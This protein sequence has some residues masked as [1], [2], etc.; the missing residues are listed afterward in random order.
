MMPAWRN[1]WQDLQPRE[2]GLISVGVSLL[3]CGLLYAYLWLP[4]SHQR[5]R[6]HELM[7]RFQMQ[8]AQLNAARDE[9]LKLKAQVGTLSR[10]QLPLRQVLE[11]SSTASGIRAQIERIDMMGDASAT[12]ALGSVSF[13]SWLLWLKE[14]QTKHS[15]R[16][17][18]C[19][20]TATGQTGLVK[21][22]ASVMRE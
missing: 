13:D 14:L 10:V 16:L 4:L 20:I 19:E 11:D 17:S 8:A 3:F 2:R 12:I 15:L 21:I 6:M 5:Q 9:V 7:P 18:S 22:Q 1:F